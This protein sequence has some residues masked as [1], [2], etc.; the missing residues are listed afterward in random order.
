MAKS[1]VFFDTEVGVDDKKIHDIGAVR[2]D[3]GI[4]HSASVQDFCAFISGTEYLCGHNIIHH[5][6]KYLGEARANCISGKV[7]DTLY[8]S[9]LLFPKRPYLVLLQQQN[10]RLLPIYATTSKRNLI[11]TLRFL[12]R[13]QQERIC[14]I[15]FCIKKLMMRSIMHY[16]L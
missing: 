11:L 6:I 5:D 13:Q 7:I 4:F 15:R 12:L 16:A 3:K 10:K 1:I 14:I 2:A 9:P 8:L